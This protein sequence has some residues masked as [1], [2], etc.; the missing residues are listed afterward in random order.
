[1]A[2]GDPGWAATSLPV[3][4]SCPLSILSSGCRWPWAAGCGGDAPERP[5][6]ANLDGI[7]QGPA[8]PGAGSPRPPPATGGQFL[9]WAARE[10]QGQGCMAR[11]WWAAAEETRRGGS[12]SGPGPAGGGGA[13]CSMAG[14]PEVLP[15]PTGSYRKTELL[16]WDSHDPVPRDCSHGTAVQGDRDRPGPSC[17]LPPPPGKP[18][19]GLCLPGALGEDQGRT[20]AQTSRPVPAASDAGRGPR[21]LPHLRARHRRS[22]RRPRPQGG[23]VRPPRCRRCRRPG[24]G[25]CEPAGPQGNDR[26]AGGPRPRPVSPAPAQGS[27]LAPDSRPPPH[28]GVAPRPG[29]ASPPMQ[30][31]TPRPGLTHPR[32]SRSPRASDLRPVSP[33]RGHPAPRIRVPAPAPAQG[34]RCAPDTHPCPEVA[35]HTRPGATP[36][37][38]PAPPPWDRPAPTSTRRP[39][40]RPATRRRSPATGVEKGRLGARSGPWRPED[41]ARARERGAVP[42]PHPAASWAGGGGT[43]T[44][45]GLRKGRT[46]PAVEGLGVGAPQRTQ[47]CPTKAPPARTPR[48]GPCPPTPPPP[49][50]PATPPPPVTQTEGNRGQRLRAQ[51]TLFTNLQCNNSHLG[52]IAAPA[53]P[54]GERLESEVAG[55]GAGSG[56]QAGRSA[57]G[58][59]PGGSGVPGPPLSADQGTQEAAAPS[60]SPGLSPSEQMRPDV[61]VVTPRDN[62]RSPSQMP[63]GRGRREA[64]TDSTLRPFLHFDLTPSELRSPGEPTE[65]I[66]Y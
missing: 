19:Q 9:L 48:Q 38:A 11:P 63:Q 27:T 47:P 30:R 59:A 62:S 21:S 31:V 37:P 28:P 20:T 49:G 13:R 6:T 56:G 53:W 17:R 26:S 45:A 50:D 7:V 39:H 42:L 32:R 65:I 55:S 43:H 57:G 2:G 1:M 25:T 44:G 33:P 18:P 10:A 51:N 4:G 12:P 58:A 8:L 61:R 54:R 15:S 29:Y 36:G 35:P 16:A 64:C 60:T 24:L 14:K 34:S 46:P 22:S 23:P 52:K 66:F 3:F 41:P 5:R 40:P